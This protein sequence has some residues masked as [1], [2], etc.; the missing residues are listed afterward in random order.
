MT[1]QARQIRFGGLGAPFERPLFREQRA[2]ALEEPAQFPGLRRFVIQF[3]ELRALLGPRGF[4]LP[5][6]PAQF[7]ALLRREQGHT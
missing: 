2:L 4:A 5:N 1:G 3:F 7:L 6:P